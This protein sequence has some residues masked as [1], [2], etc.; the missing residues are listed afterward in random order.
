[1]SL[2]PRLE[3]HSS[4]VPNSILLFTTRASAHA[5]AAQGQ[6]SP[7]SID[8]DSIQALNTRISRAEPVRLPEDTE[9]SVKPVSGPDDTQ[10]A[11]SL[12]QRLKEL[13]VSSMDEECEP[14]SGRASS[15]GGNHCTCWL[16]KMVVAFFPLSF[17]GCL[18]SCLHAAGQ[19][20]RRLVEQKYGKTYGKHSFCAQDH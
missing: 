1:M 10:L 20:L 6:P 4:A 12:N 19:T 7:S 2:A 5:D 11:A 13:S 3:R 17:V 15:L 14:C 16:S 9:P 18:R 8:E